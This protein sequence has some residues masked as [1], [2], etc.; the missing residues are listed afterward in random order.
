[1]RSLSRCSLLL[2]IASVTTSV[3]AC[4][5]EVGGAAGGSRGTSGIGAP[6]DAGGGGA[7]GN[8]GAAGSG[9]AGGSRSPSDLVY[10]GIVVATITQRDGA[11]PTY[12]VYA[13]FA[14]RSLLGRAHGSCVCQQ[15]LALPDPTSPPDAGALTL[16]TAGG[17][18]IASL[19][20]SVA[21]ESGGMTSS[22]YYG[23]WNLGDS[24]WLNVPGSYP[25]TKSRAWNP[26]E[27]IL[28]DAAGATVHAFSGTLRTGGLLSG[29][30]PSI[31]GAPLLVDRSQRLEVTWTPDRA[32][33][34]DVLLV[35][36]QLTD[37][38]V[39]SCTCEA[40]D[41]TGTLSVDPTM[42]SRF[43]TTELSGTVRLARTLHSSATTDNASIDLVGEVI[44]DGSLTFE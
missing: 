4:G 15:G 44:V 19:A 25:S 6:D 43:A 12:Q 22:S 27:D 21:T 29:V 14:R 3:L 2:S 31:G 9:G 34:E 42:L 18:A 39:L 13:D 7:A 24:P 23:D 28:V 37:D 17:T 16:R 11:T 32:S 10:G 5:G 38:G 41:S 36:E 30:V 35:L 26:G 40:P 20:P 8:G 33:G 1:M